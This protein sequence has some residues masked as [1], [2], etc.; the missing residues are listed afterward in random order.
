MFYK[1]ELLGRIKINLGI[2]EENV[3]EFVD[4]AI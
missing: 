2:E 4:I 3:N 1:I